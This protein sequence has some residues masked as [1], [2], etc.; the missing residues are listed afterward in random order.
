MKNSLFRRSR[1]AIRSLR[2]DEAILPSASWS[3]NR[4][5]WG[6]WTAHS[7]VPRA[8]LQLKRHLYETQGPSTPVSR[9]RPRAQTARSQGP[10]NAREPSSAQ[11]DSSWVSRRSFTTALTLVVSLRVRRSPTYR[12]SPAVL[13]P[14]TKQ[15]TFFPEPSAYP[16][17]TKTPCEIPVDSRQRRSPGTAPASADWFARLNAEF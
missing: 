7:R 14:I 13:F 5:A 16:L 6:P 8:V 1:A 9:A 11:D 3:R 17:C 15:R 12:R 10:G 2:V 4:A